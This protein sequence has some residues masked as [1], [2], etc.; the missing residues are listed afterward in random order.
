MIL[1]CV[2]EHAIHHWG[3]W[4]ESHLR[5][6][7]RVL[8]HL[9]KHLWILSRSKHVSELVDRLEGR[10]HRRS[11]GRHHE[12]PLSHLPHLCLSHLLLEH[13]LLS[14]HLLLVLCHL[15]WGHELVDHVT[16][17]LYSLLQ[18]ILGWLCELTLFFLDLIISN[19]GWIFGSVIDNFLSLL[20]FLF[21][22]VS[23]ESSNNVNFRTISYFAGFFQG[24]S[25][26][27]LS[28]LFCYFGLLFQFL[29]VFVVHLADNVGC[30][31]HNFVLHSTEVKSTLPIALLLRT[32]KTLSQDLLE[33]L[34]EEIFF[35]DL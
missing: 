31:L 5:H 12:L 10:H 11:L 28:L 4:H 23:T 7:L 16:S 20:N 32:T 34:Y 35:F 6:M 2:V 19:N 24:F 29:L 21:D 22:F 1:A 26:L 18:S 17:S 30:F 13:L 9:R 25:S 8:G 33:W 3:L 14:H 27:L 15:L